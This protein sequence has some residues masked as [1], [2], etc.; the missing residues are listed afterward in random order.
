LVQAW[1]FAPFLEFLPLCAAV[2]HHGG[3]G[4]VAKALTTGI[5]Q[6]ILPMAF[7]QF[8]N[9]ARVRSLGAGDSLKSGRWKIAQM[10]DSLTLWI[11]DQSRTR[12]RRVA[13]RFHGDDAFQTAAKLVEGIAY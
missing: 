6:L 12:C 4:T 1:E 8:D 7:D 9:A 10:V 2:V 11:T 13:D 3:I 5:P